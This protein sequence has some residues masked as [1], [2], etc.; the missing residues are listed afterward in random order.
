MSRLIVLALICLLFTK[1]KLQFLIIA[2]WF[3]SLCYLLHIIS[4]P[5]LS[6]SLESSLLASPVWE[7]WFWKAS[8][9]VSRECRDLYFRNLPTHSLSLL[10]YLSSS[11]LKPQICLLFH[12]CHQL[13]QGT[14]MGLC[15][16]DTCDVC[17]FYCRFSFRRSRFNK[18]EEFQGQG[19]SDRYTE[20]L[21]HCYVI[22]PG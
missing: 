9:I 6:W 20:A 3:I 12:S 15:F 1:L 14:G 22:M 2:L 10:L 18:R 17:R 21:E 11:F 4:I 13:N 5:F 19:M 8:G 7:V 16:I